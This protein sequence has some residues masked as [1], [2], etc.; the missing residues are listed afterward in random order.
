MQR[1]QLDTNFFDPAFMEDPF[2][3]YEEIRAVG[4]VVWN[5]LLPG[6]VVGAVCKVPGGAFPSYAQGYYSRSNAFYKKWD[7]IAKE[8][9]GFQAWVDQHVM[10]T[11]DFAGFRESIDREA[12]RA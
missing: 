9:V 12:V 4:N 11:K 2:P 10:G 3:L 7:K 5:G 1:K 8:R 6:W